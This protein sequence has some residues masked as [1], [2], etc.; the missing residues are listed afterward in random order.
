MKATK[1]EK[2][3]KVR[4]I[5]MNLTISEGTINR[6]DKLVVNKHVNKSKLVEKLIL[7]HIKNNSV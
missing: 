3:D 2:P 6:L 7:A 4:R 1:K 5:K